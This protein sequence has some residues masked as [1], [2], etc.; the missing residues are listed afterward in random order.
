MIVG[1]DE[2]AALAEA[3]ARMM[4]RLRIRQISGHAFHAN[5]MCSPTR[6]FDLVYALPV[7]KCHI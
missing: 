4:F 6:I 2:E 3:C 7:L 5:N 1:D